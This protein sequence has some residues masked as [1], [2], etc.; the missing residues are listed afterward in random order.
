M[1]NNNQQQRPA[2]RRIPYRV[3]SCLPNGVVTHLE[4]R[5]LKDLVNREI[6]P[7]RC[8]ESCKR[9]FQ[10]GM[11]IGDLCAETG[12]FWWARKVWLLTAGLIEDKDYNDWRYVCFDNNRVRLRDVISETECELLDRRCSDLWRALGHPEYAWWDKRV[13]YLSSRYFGTCYYYLFA[14]KYDGYYD[15]LIGEFEEKME[16]YRAEQ[17]T[18]QTF[19]DAQGDNLPPC[20]QDFYEY[21]HDGPHTE[22]FS[23]LDY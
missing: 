22:D 19:R 6:H 10:K 23:W 18:Q 15:E 13:E 21:W 2:R 1:R 14:D 11:Y 5:L 8:A 4:A 17:T 20:S 12:H 3:C 16:Y 7:I 9:K